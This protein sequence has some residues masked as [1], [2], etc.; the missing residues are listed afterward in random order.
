MTFFNGGV[1]SLNLVKYE[2]YLQAIKTGTTLETTLSNA[3]LSAIIHSK[4]AELVSLK[5]TKGRAYIWGGNSEFWG[6]HS[7]ILFPI[8]GTLKGNHY[9]YN[10]QKYQL[11]RHGF[12]RDMPFE[13]IEKTDSKVTFSLK[14]STETKI[15]YPFDFELQISYTLEENGLSVGYKIFNATNESMPFSIG[16]HPAFALPE[17]FESYTLAFEFNEE[18]KS[19]IL[20]NDLLSDNSFKVILH[21]NKL[22]LTYSLFE[23]DALIFKEIQSKRITLL[24]NE[25][26]ILTIHYSDF[27]NFGIW[28]KINAPFICLEPWLGY[29]DTYESSGNIN[30]KEGIQFVG[31]NSAFLCTFK[32]EI[33]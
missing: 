9:R 15:I 31:A 6:K 16:A 3:T 12:A 30:E 17:T 23:N 19:Y 2:I 1:F 27:K 20:E 13:L 8:V 22:P 29:S 4:G 7:P 28:T 24:E 14:A 26:P 5:N 21:K 32:I 25:K 18:L 10:N 33:L 11:P